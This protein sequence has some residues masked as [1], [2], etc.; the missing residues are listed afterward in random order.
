MDSAIKEEIIRQLD[1]LPVH[2]IGTSGIQHVVR[3]PYC[4]DSMNPSHGHFSIRID[5]SDP[6]DPM[7]FNCLRCPASGILNA[8]TLADLQLNVNADTAAR[9]SKLT[10]I[11]CRIHHITA[12]KTESFTNPIPTTSALTIDK[13]EFVRNRIG[14]N[15]TID[16][17]LN[18]DIV[19]NLIDFMSW[20]K[21]ENVYVGE[22]CSPGMIRFLNEHYVGFLGKNRNVITLRYMD[23]IPPDQLKYEPKRYIKC[24]I[25]PKN[26]DPNS[27]YSIPNKIDILY[28]H[29]VTVHIA[30]GPFDILS[31]LYNCQD[32]NLD[33]NFYYAICGFGYNSVISNVV[34]MGINT[35][36]NLHIYA[37]RDKTDNEIIGALTKSSMVIWTKK[38]FIHRN[39]TGGKDF[40]VPKEE[41]I[42][43]C[44]R[45]K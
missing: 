43:T 22:K 24:K 36:I 3:C 42:D 14:A 39:G 6:L 18:M 32:K 27:Y 19:L 21:I 37:D 11:S 41:I 31:V 30:E 29:D 26:L 15:I 12:I 16:D 10:Q 5:T 38:I 40:G 20:N 45:V 9:L 4:G 28:T 2:K 33:N 17:C 13:L 1:L 44:R 25:H 7:L 35:G 8:Q 23:D 34:R